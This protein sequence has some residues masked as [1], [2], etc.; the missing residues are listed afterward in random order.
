M[1]F[2]PVK[3]KRGRQSSDEFALHKTVGDKIF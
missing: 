3:K 1:L 2:M